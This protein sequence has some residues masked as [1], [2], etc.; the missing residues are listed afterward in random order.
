[1]PLETIQLK[2]GH[3]NEKKMIL[4]AE[5]DCLTEKTEALSNLA[6]LKEQMKTYQGV[7]STSGFSSDDVQRGKLQ[8][9]LH[10]VIKM[11]AAQQ[12]CSVGGY[13]DSIVTLR[14]KIQTLE[15]FLQD[16]NLEEIENQIVIYQAEIDLIQRHIN[17]LTEEKA[18]R[19]EYLATPEPV[20]PVVERPVLLQQAVQPIVRR[21]REGDNLNYAGEMF[22][23]TLRGGFLTQCILMSF[24]IATDPNVSFK[25]RVLLITVMTTAAAAMCHDAYRIGKSAYSLF[26]AN[27]T[28]STAQ[29]SPDK[30]RQLPGPGRH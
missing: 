23:A 27:S 19:E 30:E 14:Q 1:M 28:T 21:N 20:A 10:Q 4:S 25:E 24:K 7:L 15:V 3:L 18:E 5:I 2:L 17:K 29:A 6:R 11:I 12:R 26:R 9:D 22:F 13:V 8:P 16:A